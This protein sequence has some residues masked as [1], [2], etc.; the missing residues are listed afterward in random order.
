MDRPKPLP[1]AFVVK[2][3]SNIFFN[4]SLGMPLP[5]SIILISILSLNSSVSIVTEPSSFIA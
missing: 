5:V 1:L 3:G 4:L 2:K